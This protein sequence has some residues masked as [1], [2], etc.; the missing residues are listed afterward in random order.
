LIALNYVPSLAGPSWNF[1]RRAVRLDARIL[2]K[3]AKVG[4]HLL[5]VALV[6]A[7]LFACARDWPESALRVEIESL[8]DFNYL[9]AADGL[10]IENRYSEALLVVETG[11]LY[12]PAAMQPQLLDEH[13]QIEAERDSLLRRVREV[14]YGALTGQGSSNEALAGAVA[15]DLLVVGDFRDLT[16]QGLHAVRGEATDDTIMALSAAGIGFTFAPEVD[17]GVALLKFA[18]RASALTDNFARSI[19]RLARRALQM[20]SKDELMQVGNDVAEL[21]RNAKPA[22]AIGILRHVDDPEMLHRAAWF[23]GEP[24]GALTLWLGEDKALQ[25]LKTADAGS[26]H[27]LLRAGRKGRAGIDLL[28]ANGS[29]FAQPH[30]LLGLLKGFYKGNVPALLEGWIAE[31][32]EAIIGVICGWLLYEL[33]LLIAAV[34]PARKRA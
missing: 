17:W 19:A 25:W 32:A 33:V 30:F 22:A 1:D 10:R 5:R 20:H 2:T 11:Y 3:I 16:I 7:L 31:Y 14:G 9:A 15:S 26:D 6:A 8:P 28:A 34:A 13:A 18:R 12:A 24:G 23:S 4:K 29:V 21:S 27:W